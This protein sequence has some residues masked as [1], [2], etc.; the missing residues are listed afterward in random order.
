M[1]VLPLLAAAIVAVLPQDTTRTGATVRVRVTHAES[2]VS[3]AIVRSG[4]IGAQTDAAGTAILRLPA[5]RHDLITSRLG[6]TPDT[7]ALTLTAGQDTSVA[8][9]LE[10]QAAEMESVVIASTRTSR[11]VEDSP[12][13]VEVVDEE[14][15]AEKTAM[16]PGD[17]A[18]MLNET[19]GLR[20]QTTSPSLGGASVRVQGLRGRYTLL[21]ADGLPLYGGQAGGLGLLQIPPVDLARAEVIKGTASALYGS[22]ALGGVVNLVSRRPDDEPVREMLANQTSRGGSDLVAF[23][24][25]RLGAVT[26]G[27]ESPLGASLLVSAHRQRANDLDDDGWAD[28]AEYERL[29]ARPRFFFDR[30]P[31]SVFATI[32]FT[33]EDRDG[34]TLE[35]QTAPDGLPYIEALRTRRV[36]AGTV[37]RWVIDARDVLSIR[38]S[39]VEQRHRHTF[40][41]VRERDRHRT[42]F[43]EASLAVPRGRWT[44][45][46]GA[47]YQSERYRNEDITGFD[48]DFRVP[49]V[50]AQADVD[51]ASWLAL[52]ASARV[53]WHNEYA[54]IVSPRVSALLRASE[55]SELA[56]WNIR[57]SGGAGTFA[58]VPFTEETEVSGLGALQP[59]TG[60]QAERAVGGSLDVNGPVRTTLG[61]LEVNATVFASRLSHA[62]AAREVAGDPRM[63]ML[64]NAPL[65]AR[66]WGAE[67]L[68]R[69]VRGRARITG[70]Y[71]F[72]RA[73]EWNPDRG[74]SNVRRDVPLA[75]R[76]TAG[77]VGSVEEEE[78]F[79]IGLELY[80]TGRQALEDNPYRTS[81]RPYLI[82]GL[83]G[84]RW[85]ETP[86]G[87]ARVFLNLENI[88]NVRQTR[89]DPLLL[90]ER[91]KGGRW[92]TD[93][94]TELSGFTINGGVRFRF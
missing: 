1:P 58:P 70:T 4:A 5:G 3:G 10:E 84:E 35:G 51:P 7:L 93:A 87:T 38:G 72:L 9:A 19:S 49:S 59:L 34:G 80:Y 24:S 42:W 69:L 36:D 22:S 26:D 28:M 67:L 29:V 77:I 55:E 37:G 8:I 92:T 71:A 68:A 23:A 54:T 73:T 15:V 57:L 75:P 33:G 89:Y 14:E 90:P 61:A 56:G 60:L 17:I 32:G 45:V 64:V 81:S 86:A 40:G 2:A 65:D 78:R 30:G 53:D 12:L 91:G 43:T 94:W 11:R 20:V 85:I 52:S 46:A 13:R 76:H 47:A 63:L 27:E 44:Y 18:M 74:A 39:A 82:V 62:V 50:F 79:R 21:L 48:F 6:F 83:L 66:T 16:T 31:S 88:G 41:P 25:Q